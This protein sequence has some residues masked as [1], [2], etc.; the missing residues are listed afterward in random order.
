MYGSSLLKNDNAT[1]PPFGSMTLSPRI[2]NCQ[3]QSAVVV[4]FGLF[5]ERIKSGILGG[6]GIMYTFGFS[7]KPTLIYE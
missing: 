4:P 5:F 3:K 6:S 1:G 7:L 2:L